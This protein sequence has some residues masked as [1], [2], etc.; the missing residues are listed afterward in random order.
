MVDLRHGEHAYTPL[1]E[2]VEPRSEDVDWPPR[3]IPRWLWRPRGCGKEGYRPGYWYIHTR[4]GDPPT[5]KLR[6]GQAIDD[7]R[8]EKVRSLRK[9]V[10]NVY[11]LGFWG[12][13]WEVVFNREQDI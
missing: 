13:L 3:G 6:D 8:W 7:T 2:H 4:N 11:D 1:P 12:N 9:E 10:D 5:I